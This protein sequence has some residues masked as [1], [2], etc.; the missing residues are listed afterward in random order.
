MDVEFEDIPDMPEREKPWG[1]GH[2]V[3]VAKDIIKEPFAVAK[4]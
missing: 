2:A 1:T 3:L 4:C